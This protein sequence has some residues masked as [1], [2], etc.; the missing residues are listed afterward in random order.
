MKKKYIT[1]VLEVT[2]L[3]PDGA[4]AGS[5]QIPL[6]PT[7]GAWNTDDYFGQEGGSSGGS[8][9]NVGWRSDEEIG[10]EDM[11]ARRSFGSLW[12]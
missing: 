6:T 7:Y 9:G 4:L 11:F 3:Q 5:N 12:E 8:G 10:G 2:L 1:P